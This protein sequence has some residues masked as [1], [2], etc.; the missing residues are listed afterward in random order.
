MR[1]QRG[2]EVSSSDS[3]SGDSSSDH[4]LG[5]FLGRPEFK[6]AMLENTQLVAS[7]QLPL[8]YIC[9]VCLNLFESSYEF[10]SMFSLI[11]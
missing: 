3:Q 5:V 7:S 8:G 4:K 1:R 10:F 9:V 6:I 2:W 11:V